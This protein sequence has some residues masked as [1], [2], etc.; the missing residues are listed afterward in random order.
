M[1]R[2][3]VAKLGT[4]LVTGPAGGI[5]VDVLDSVARQT[6]ELFSQ[7]RRV[8]IVS[9]GAV[10]AGVKALGMSGRPR[11]LPRL[12]AAA[13]AGQPLLAAAWAKSL[14][15]AGLKTGQVLLTREDV[16]DRPRF[17][18]VRNTIAALWHAG[19][20]PIVNENDAVSTAEL[21]A[22]TSDGADSFGDNDRLAAVM[23]AALSAELL[24]LLTTVPGL[25]DDAGDVV[26]QVSDLADARR[27]CRSDVST[28]GTGG[29]TS[30]LD[31]AELVTAA[32][33]RMVLADGRS[34]D[35]LLRAVAGESVGTT[36]LP[37]E[38]PKLR[39]RLRWVQHATTS[40]R[41]VLDDGAVQALSKRPASL[42]PAGVTSVEG[43]F[44]R[45]DVVELV[46]VDGTK[47][48]RGVAAHHASTCR[49]LAG[50]RSSDLRDE[51]GEGFQAELVHRDQLLLLRD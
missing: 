49:H 6:A 43:D 5:D 35:A 45:G 17:L 19:A 1:P 48:A 28:G 10:G 2:V 25:L 51:F 40:G 42:L 31:A 33:E 8:A 50:K 7:N 12:Q 29:M 41:L 27:W 36:F 38:E 44:C 39:A 30:K 26:P 9:S 4:A 24:V 22:G 21:A 3:I 37:K 16:D 46:T 47:F 20:V 34:P 32:G 23:S 18:N 13:A 15:A 11:D 14:D